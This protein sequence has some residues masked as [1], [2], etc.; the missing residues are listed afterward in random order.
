MS[1]KFGREICGQL[2]IAEG[3]EWLVTNG[4]GGYASGTVAGNLTRSYHGL[5]VAALQPPLQRT[6][7]LSKID[8]LVRYDGEEY[9]LATNR[10]QG[11][12]ISPAGYQNIESFCLEGTIPVW[13]F[14]I[15]DALLEKRIW[16]QPKA[17]TTYVYYTL[18]RGS[19]P[20]DLTLK[21][22][23]NY[24]SFHGGIL[25]ALKSQS[26]IKNGVRVTL[27]VDNPQSFYLLCDR[28]NVSLNN[29]VY[30]DF[31]LPREGYRGLNDRD[32]H[33]HVATFTATLQPGES[34]TFVASTAIP[35]ALTGES[36]NLDD[37]DVSIGLLDGQRALS[38]RHNY[39]RELIETWQTANPDLEL[40]APIQQL[41]L[42]ADQFI[43]DRQIPNHA[44][45]KSVIAGYHWFNDWGRDTMIS[46]P[47]LTLATGRPKIARS[48][49]ATF[50]EYISEGMLPNRFPDS[51]RLTDGDY[52]TVDATLWYFEAVRQYY[53]QTE[54]RQ[55]LREIFPKLAEIIDW[56][57]RGTRYGIK[58][59]DDGL[60]KAGVEGV[61]LTWMDA[62]VNGEVITPRCGKPVEINALWYN[63]LRTMSAFAA[64]LGKD[65]SQYEQMA[66]TTKQGFKRFW[67]QD[68]G[69]CFDVLDT[70]EGT[71]DPALR[72]NQIFAL[73]LPESPLD[74][75]QQQSVI[76]ACERSLLTSY[77]LR[78]LDRHHPQYQG[79][80]GGDRYERD[81]AYHQGTVWGWLIGAFALAH[82]RVYGD[83]DR[84]LSFL[85]P[86]IEH[87]TNAGLGS[88]SEIFDGDAP[89]TP[90]G[91]I[92]QAWS[93]AEVLRAWQ[94][95]ARHDDDRPILSEIL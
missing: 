90:R 47:G 42:A 89:F 6:L 43:V 70:P 39:E 18:K 72:P 82:L 85:T 44:E 75:K 80:Y 30:T 56:H 62:L 84:S 58:L 19:K 22:L 8:D 2:E 52:N 15:A 68:T 61:Q 86:A 28:A 31:Q 10:W 21:T 50:A 37:N 26:V 29:E 49:I 17:N 71:N 35:N 63:A 88:I 57:R 78:S 95:I 23:V 92:A 9:P 24:R 60:L 64:T 94:I 25:P 73:S 32:C 14:A 69:Y 1:I 81:S 66:E 65:A 93:V 5:L 55:F 12:N 51:D 74:R 11:N 40:T 67:N 7:L 38:D 76:Q 54:D 34:L 77:G 45:G 33:L 87:L 41:V 16:M 46:L 27:D 53:A 83:G 48:I 79:H 13:Q 20:I 91:C 59:D 3:R 4:I 36:L